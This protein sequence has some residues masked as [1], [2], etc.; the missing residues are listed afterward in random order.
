[1]IIEKNNKSQNTDT[2]NSGP[3]QNQTDINREIAKQFF[4]E[5]NNLYN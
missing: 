1:M 4:F 2:Y 3:D 5:K